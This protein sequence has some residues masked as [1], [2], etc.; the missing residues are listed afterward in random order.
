M[1]RRP[2]HLVAK[3]TGAACNLDCSYCFFLSKEALWDPR[4]Q[5]MSE[6][7]LRRFIERYLAAQPDGEVEIAWQGGE[8]T[9]RGLDF[10]RT[11]VAL[12]EEMRRPRQRVR[13]AVQTNATLIDEQ[14]AD[15]LADNRFLVGVSVDGPA[16]L[17]DRYRVNRAGR[18]TYRQVVRGLRTLQAHD[19]DV[20]LLCTVNAGN[21]EEPLRVYRHLRDELD[22]SFIQ[23]IPIV[24]RVSTG[25]EAVAEA[26]WRDDEGRRVLYRQE[27]S[28]TTSRSVLPEAWGRFL[29]E[30]FDEWFAHDVGRVFIQHAEVM[31][32]AALGRYSL[33]VHAPE[34]GDAPA[35]EHN[36]DVY[37]CD[38][39]VEPG[40]RLGSVLSDDFQAMLSSPRQRA[41]GAAKRSALPGQCLRCPVRWACHGGCPKDRFDVTRDGQG[42]LNHLCAGYYAFFTHAAPTVLR[43]AEAVQR[44][45]PVTDALGADDA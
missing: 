35:M 29:I 42:G 34:C 14:W 5:R 17:H 15:F 27:G 25:E 36:G 40:Y 43:M 7:V 22:A 13:H 44:G 2:F 32:G 9:M 16:D 41:F 39:F 19:V 3:P 33:C 8:P 38:H 6:P 10:F 23:F 12:V 11:A 31:L 4:G 26:G 24:E 21:V 28:G 1:R 20:N 30:V 45:L 18:G 37:S